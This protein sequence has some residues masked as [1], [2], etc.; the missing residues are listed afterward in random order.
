M[1][2][3]VYQSLLKLFVICLLFLS[4]VYAMLSMTSSLNL[5]VWFSIIL[6]YSILYNIFIKNI[7]DN[8]FIIYLLS[9]IHILY[10][11]YSTT[12]IIYYKCIIYYIIHCLQS[13]L[14]I[15]GETLLLI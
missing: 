6:E 10:S 13:I 14:C 5:I 1:Y 9:N 2:T 11:Y 4:R 15:S 8:Y 7:Y 3:Q 12:I